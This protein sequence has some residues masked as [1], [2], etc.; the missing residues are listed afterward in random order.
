M[1]DCV[2]LKDYPVGTRF[3]SL[4]TNNIFEILSK[5]Y[6]N[7]KIIIINKTKNIQS[8]YNL[9]ECY[10]S[11]GIVLNLPPAKEIEWE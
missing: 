10:L 7:N 11:S 8:V 5:N 2:Y 4:R 6:N 1:G 3:K 9:K